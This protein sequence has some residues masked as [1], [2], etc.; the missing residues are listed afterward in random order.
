V[1]AQSEPFFQRR[2]WES[3]FLLFRKIVKVRMR[4]VDMLQSRLKLTDDQ[5]Y[6]TVW[7]VTLDLL[8]TAEAIGLKKENEGLKFN[9]MEGP[10][11]VY[12]TEPFTSTRLSIATLRFIEELAIQRGSIWAQRRIANNPAVATLDAP[13]PRRLPIQALWF[14]EDKDDKR[15]RGL[16]HRLSFLASKAKGVVFLRAEHALRPKP[17]SSSVIEDFVDDYACAL[18]LSLSWCTPAEK[19][20]RLPK[21]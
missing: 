15:I 21:A 10:L 3:V 14:L 9:D 19:E 11:K 5:V 7:Q 6:S 20:S 8:L 16:E 18:R 4:R 17:D 12:G 13:W 2:H 1:L